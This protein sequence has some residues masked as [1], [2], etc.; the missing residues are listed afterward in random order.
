[1]PLNRRTFFT[2]LFVEQTSRKF[3][4]SSQGATYY[5]SLENDIIE[6]NSFHSFKARLKKKKKKM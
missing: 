6:T 2:F 1:M 4:A 3:S 5:N